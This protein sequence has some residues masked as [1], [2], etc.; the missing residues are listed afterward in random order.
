MESIYFQKLDGI[1]KLTLDE[2][3][4]MSHFNLYTMFIDT[5]KNLASHMW[6]LKEV[7]TAIAITRFLQKSPQLEQSAQEVLDATH[8]SL[9][10]QLKKRWTK[11]TQTIDDIL[12]LDYLGNKNK[13]E[14]IHRSLYSDDRW[15]DVCNQL[16]GFDYIAEYMVNLAKRIG[17]ADKLMSY[18][19]IARFELGSVAEYKSKARNGKVVSLAQRFQ[20]NLKDLMQHAKDLLDS[21]NISAQLRIYDGT[22]IC[23]L[24]MCLCMLQA[25]VEYIAL[26]NELVL[27][28]KQQS[29]AT[30]SDLDMMR[31]L[32]RIY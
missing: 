21:E 24:C 31:E 5:L 18:K 16:M 6:T 19:Q 14:C 1:N 2:R 7:W 8:I 32:K 27:E 12:E 28:K 23:A 30:S 29:M 10:D 3:S 22:T 15:F 11:S 26:G 13:A 25:P 9:E 4:E 17:Y 20:L